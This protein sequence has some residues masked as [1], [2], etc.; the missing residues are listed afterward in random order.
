MKSYHI[1]TPSKIV[2]AAATRKDPGSASKITGVLKPSTSTPLSSARR[3][4]TRSPSPGTKRSA[5]A[6]AFQSEQ[7]ARSEINTSRSKP[8]EDRTNCNPEEDEDDET[9]PPVR[10]E[11]DRTR[12]HIAGPSATSSSSSS[13][14]RSPGRGAK[15]G[16]TSS[17]KLLTG[18]RRG[19]MMVPTSRSRTST[20]RNYNA[21]GASAATAAPSPRPLRVKNDCSADQQLPQ[22]NPS[23]RPEHDSGARTNGA[24][25]LERN[26]VAFSEG[27]R[28]AD[29]DYSRTKHGPPSSRSA[30]GSP[31]KKLQATRIRMPMPSSTSG[32]TA[33]TGPDTP[34]G[35]S[36]INV[37]RQVTHWKSL[38][39]TAI[40]DFGSER[41]KWEEEFA[42]YRLKEEKW[43]LEKNALLEYIEET[44]KR[45]AVTG[46]ARGLNST[47]TGSSSSVNEL[48]YVKELQGQLSHALQQ[49]NFLE[50]AYSEREYKYSELMQQKTQE[51]HGYCAKTEQMEKLT[52]K[53]KKENQ[54]LLNREKQ[55]KQQSVV[56][57]KKI[58][59]DKQ[60]LNDC[61]NQLQRQQTALAELQLKF[62]ETSENLK[63]CLQENELLKS[64]ASTAATSAS[65]GERERRESN[66]RAD[67][68]QA[69]LSRKTD[70]MGRLKQEFAQQHASSQAMI[71]QMRQ[72][73]QQVLRSGALIQ[74]HQQQQDVG[75]GKK[76]S[77]DGTKLLV[78]NNSSGGAA[79]SSGSSGADLYG[80]IN[81]TTPSRPVMASH[82]GEQL[83]EEMRHR[84]ETIVQ[85]VRE[86]YASFGHEL[87]W[88]STSQLRARQ[89]VSSEQAE[90]EVDVVELVRSA[91]KVL[92]DYARRDVEGQMQH[93]HHLAPHLQERNPDPHRRRAAPKHTYS[94]GDELVDQHVA[95][96]TPALRDGSFCARSTNA[97]RVAGHGM[98]TGGT[99]SG[100]S[101]NPNG[102]RIV[103]VDEGDAGGAFGQERAN[104]LE[105]HDQFREIHPPQ[106]Y[107]CE[108]DI[109]RNGHDVQM[110]SS[111]RASGY[112][113]V[114]Q[115]DNH[116]DYLHAGGRVPPAQAPRHEAHHQKMLHRSIAD[117]RGQQL[118]EQLGVLN[119]TD[120]SFTSTFSVAEHLRQIKDAFVKVPPGG[121][122]VS[123]DTQY[124]ATAAMKVEDQRQEPNSTSSSMSRGPA[125]WHEERRINTR[126]DL[127]GDHDRSR[128]QVHNSPGG[129]ATFSAYENSSN[130]QQPPKPPPL[131]FPERKIQYGADPPR[132][133]DDAFISS[134][135]GPP[136]SG[137][138][139]A[140]AMK[141]A[142]L[143][144]PGGNS[145]GTRLQRENAP[146]SATRP[147]SDGGRTTGNN[148]NAAGPRSSPA[149][150][151]SSSSTRRRNER[152]PLNETAPA[153]MML[154][155]TA[156][157]G[158]ASNRSYAGGGG[159]SSISSAAKQREAARD[160]NHTWH[161]H[162]HL[163]S[164]TSQVE[165]QEELQ[166]QQ[167]HGD[168]FHNP[169]TPA[170]TSN[171][172]VSPRPV[173]L[174]DFNNSKTSPAVL[175]RTLPGPPTRQHRPPRSAP[176]H[177]AARRG[178]S[179]APRDDQQQHRRS[180]ST[181]NAGT[182]STVLQPPALGG[183]GR[184]GAYPGEEPL[185]RN[186]NTRT[187]PHLVATQN[188]DDP[189]NEVEGVAPTH[190]NG[191]T[192]SRTEELTDK[193]S[194][195]RKQFASIRRALDLNS[196]TRG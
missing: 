145:F 100:G 163:G 188:Y 91:L 30:S 59:E 105:D 20:P 38:Y 195:V 172:C 154:N 28:R 137:R 99:S 185:D 125:E 93:E 92:S 51:L 144:L 176:A 53:L 124:S 35:S 64:S 180:P 19:S 39:E 161:H 164:W 102:M 148:A 12:V 32:N 21:A 113:D 15:T 126:N 50:E 130:R 49:Q 166:A 65:A 78:L 82:S 37:N 183:A 117:E 101:K 17:A 167:E 157:S 66:E 3:E 2:T 72:K 184:G 168:F 75:V 159:T 52:E 160:M 152:Q 55:A 61:K 132:V 120:T 70:E 43:N 1:T 128:G 151:P 108:A 109:A 33:T 71:G 98:T 60:L 90:V 189:V 194:M 121:G 173:S 67:L 115:M 46:T 122:R 107:D 42:N 74:Q 45:D 18:D 85:M 193:I 150:A 57:E 123:R 23:P 138:A 103:F 9:G 40:E 13:Y 175:P 153:E 5:A 4:T 179:P 94:G 142:A 187:S 139:P 41:S 147:S 174:P 190:H 118:D 136:P 16:S 171:F 129:P 27:A 119:K 29:R 86:V 62:A 79:T 58:N 8:G 34:N 14:C 146:Y 7:Q 31:V 25:K 169:T 63:L 192:T 133:A 95:E 170:T 156:T 111:T 110:L 177:E 88:P 97:G 10:E 81:T 48:N 47:S 196:T 143:Q 89:T 162:D 56:F 134:A 11:H 114:Q 69:E 76:L 140:P 141:I 165:Q 54:Q 181:T 22:I 68:L 96:E 36:V 87:S 116:D 26:Q 84:E 106:E 191:A 178:G 44:R 127:S 112:E 73:L 182:P 24:R 104:Y 149:A 77:D 131:P 83:L 155:L 6:A 80:T 158:W 186:G 135:R